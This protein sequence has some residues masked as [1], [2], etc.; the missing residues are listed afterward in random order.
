MTLTDYLDRWQAIQSKEA[1]EKPVVIFFDQ[2]EELFTSH[3]DRWRDRSGVFEQVGD[4]LKGSPSLLRPG[5]IRDPELLLDPHFS[6][7]S[8]LL[9]SLARGNDQRSLEELIEKLHEELSQIISLARN[10]NFTRRCDVL[11]FRDQLEH[12]Q[13]D[14]L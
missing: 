6:K 5:D 10:I 13:C 3:L 9:G 12:G 11:S 1:G 4:A 8:K 7:V 2:F 14:F